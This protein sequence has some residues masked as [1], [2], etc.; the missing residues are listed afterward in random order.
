MTEPTKEATVTKTHK[1]MP[2]GDGCYILR[3]FGEDT[4]CPDLDDN[5]P[6]KPRCLKFA[7]E[8]R[9]NI[10]GRILKCDECIKE[11]AL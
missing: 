2:E 5:I 1:F 10:S 7:V 8:L 4:V 6:M 11:T 9:W 3:I